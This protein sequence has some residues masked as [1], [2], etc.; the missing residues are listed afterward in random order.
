MRLPLILGALAAASA[1]SLAAVAA[2]D[3]IAARQA[4]M[5][6]NGGAAA[7]SAGFLRNEIPYNATAARAALLSFNATAMVYGDFFPEGTEDPSRSKAAPTIWTDRAG[8]DAAIAE[9]AQVSAAAV[10][11]S[12]REGPADLAAFQAAVQ[13]V[14][15]TCRSCHET[16][17]LPD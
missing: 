10:E 8:F 17:Q 7:V 3:P 9:F 11:A 12:G 16:Y 13:P 5:S 14:L 2:E 4:L 15:E 1:V 6:S